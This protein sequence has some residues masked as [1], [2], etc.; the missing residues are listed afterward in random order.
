M[1]FVEAI[2]P[3]PPWDNISEFETRKNYESPLRKN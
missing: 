2:T 1:L 3:I